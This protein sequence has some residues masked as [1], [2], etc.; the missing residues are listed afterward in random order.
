MESERQKRVEELYLAARELKPDERPAFLRE[1][2]GEDAELR[3]EVESLLI[4]EERAQ[5]F[6][7]TPA[8]GVAARLLAGAQDPSSVKRFSPGTAVGPYRIESLLGAGG[9]GEVYKARD[10]RLDRFVALKFL[11]ERYLEDQSALERFKREARAASALNHPHICTIHDIG[12]H[13]GRPFMVMELLEGQS[14]KDC[15]GS[16][17]LPFDEALELALQITDALD[18]AHNKGITH[19]DIKPANIFVTERGQAKILDFG[20]AKLAPGRQASPDAATLSQH[21]ITSPGT[22]MGTIAYMSPEQVRGEEVDARTDLFSFGVVLYEMATRALPFKGNATGLIFDAILHQEPDPPSQLNPELPADLERVILRALE[23]DREV[24]CQTA[25]DLKAELKRLRREWESGRRAVSSRES[26]PAIPGHLPALAPGRYV[27]LVAAAALVLAIGL[28]GVKL[29]WFSRSS[30][31]SLPESSQRQLTANPVEDPVIR[32]AI[33]PD[34][35]YVAYTDLTGIH[36]LLVNAGE[37][38]V[39][40]VPQEG[41][42]FR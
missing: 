41:F 18:A 33:S 4:H 9:M 14:L 7:E 19:R 29:G 32:A 27:G 5:H 8:L 25:S 42:C 39:L 20:L 10:T 21:L 22:A 36:L 11:P 15:I 16:K 2:C 26:A 3:R 30:R 24:R 23:K 31:E 35:K 6:L 40:P 37:N 34:G 13:Q 17:A 1:A 28:A 12:E 38:R